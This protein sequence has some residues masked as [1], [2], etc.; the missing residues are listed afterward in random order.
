M[1]PFLSSVNL[2]A[3]SEAH[4][5]PSCHHAL[6]CRTW[7][8]LLNMQ[9]VSL[10]QRSALGPHLG[11]FPLKSHLHTIQIHCMPAPYAGRG[12]LLLA[13]PQGHLLIAAFD[14]LMLKIKELDCFWI[15]PN[16]GDSSTQTWSLGVLSNCPCLRKPCR[17][18]S[19]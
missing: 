2:S 17:N 9:V 12:S 19:P 7:L 16:S 13:L 6:L 8:H 11:T 4:C 1:L 10:L 15:R 18:M 5:F 3:L 14:D